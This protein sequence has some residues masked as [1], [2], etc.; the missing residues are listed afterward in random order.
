MSRA[1][2]LAAVAFNAAGC[3][4]A[5]QAGNSAP[6]PAIVQAHG[7]SVGCADC[8]S[9]TIEPELATAIETRVADLKLRGGDCAAY[10]AVLESSF[11]RGQI[12]IRPFMWRVGTQLAS[13]EARP[14]GEMI[15]AREIDPLNV[16]VRTIQDVLWT[17]EHEA[18][19][20][21]FDISN[22][23]DRAADRANQRV[24]ECRDAV[25]AAEGVSRR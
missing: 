25:L 18:A 22:V 10:G 21:A 8:D 11:R 2:L 16:G 1:L 13:G 23:A 6:L 15:L 14:N 19:H 20:I 7:D 12:S 24:R 5:R 9:S 3:T 17:M 4:A